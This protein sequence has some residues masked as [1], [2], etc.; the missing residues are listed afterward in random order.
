MGHTP[1]TAPRALKV[2]RVPLLRPR[3][4]GELAAAIRPPPLRP[5]KIASLG[6]ARR[7]GH[8]RCHR[9]EKTSE[10]TT[11]SALGFRVVFMGFAGWAERLSFE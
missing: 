3:R 6:T 9:N 5:G 7:E 1:Y 2:I 11:F 8:E 4:A 10:R